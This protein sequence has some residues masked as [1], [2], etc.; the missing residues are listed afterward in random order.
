[1]TPG[2][3]GGTRSGPRERILATLARRR[4]RAGRRAGR[5]WRT[6]VLPALLRQPLVAIHVQE[7]GLRDQVEPVLRWLADTGQVPIVVIAPDDAV[8][9]SRDSAGL[10]R[11][12]P[13]GP[14]L[15]TESEFA[16][17]RI[18]PAVLLTLHPE[19]PSAIGAGLRA[20]GC[21]RA[22]MQHGLSDKE[23]FAS[24]F[25][26]DPL[27]HVDV[28]LLAGPAF[29]RGSL[30]RYLERHPEACH[31]LQVLAAGLPKTD[32]LIA[33]PE[34]ASRAAGR[35]G[36]RPIVCYAPTY[37][38]CASLQEN[39]IAIIRALA[40]LPVSV[41]VRL[42]HWS[43]KDP[44]V[45]PWVA[46]ETD[47][48]RWPEAIEALSRELPNVGLATDDAIECLESA[49][50]LVSDA[51]GIAFEFMLLDRP[52]VFFDVPRL[53]ERYGAGGVHAWGRAG[54][55]VVSTTGDLTAAVARALA[56]PGRLRRERRAIVD[57]LLYVPGRAT[58]TC[59][60]HLLDLAAAP[61]R[62]AVDRVPAGA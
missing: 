39:G 26:D 56:D 47:G 20:S 19:T 29:R 34:R 23:V 40:S 58:E 12:D 16:R 3:Q 28:V 59:G 36:G 33:T 22:V 31:R 6:R 21:W 2:P 32:R 8:A 1:V 27:E 41:R 37:E 25:V 44:A 55:D 51:S 30:S 9:R 18:E 53:F 48:I 10:A 15:V 5:W 35:P 52:V 60:R 57:A 11:P 46:A 38:R 50:V 49:D 14:C 62:G 7:P 4:D 45:H 13:F 54:G 43:A 17:S 61:R 42:H 24:R